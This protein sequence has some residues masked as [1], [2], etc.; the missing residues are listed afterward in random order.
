MNTQYIHS[1][2]YVYDIITDDRA[3]ILEHPGV[4]DGHRQPSF[5][6]CW[7][8]IFP[9][10]PVCPSVGRAV[11]REGRGQTQRKKACLTVYIYKKNTSGVAG[12]RDLPPPPPQ[13]HP[14]LYGY[15]SDAVLPN[16]EMER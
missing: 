7:K 14:A 6:P 13:H 2:Y 3:I 4:L 9:S 8:F 11:S 5:G 10:D 12:A 16:Q 15:E 1:K